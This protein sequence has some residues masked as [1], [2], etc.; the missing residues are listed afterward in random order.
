MLKNL[1]AHPL[2]R[3]ID[4]DDPKTTTLRREIIRSKPFLRRIYD[5]WY[6]WIA[7]QIPRG[8]GGVL[9]LGSGAGFFDE[10][11]PETITSEI[12]LLPGIRCVLDGQQMPFADASLKAIVM[13]DVLHHLPRVRLFFAEAVR[14]LR[15]GG[16]VAMVEPWNTAWSRL[17]YQNLH[18]E[19]FRPEA[20]AWEFPSSGPLS[21]ANG[22][23]PWICLARDR[24]SFEREFPQLAIELIQ[25]ILPLRYL[26]SGGVSMRSL[27]PG[28]AS[29]PVSLLEA[30]WPGAMFARLLLRRR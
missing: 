19:P 23:L 27:M 26:L 12:F 11:V 21:G 4:L 16:V 24:A 6:R 22:A 18:H 3:G 13:S 30:A 14:T 7:D 1:L 20:D 15:P 9:E 17:I 2:T 28:F 29:G 5:E 10:L 25:P 8:A